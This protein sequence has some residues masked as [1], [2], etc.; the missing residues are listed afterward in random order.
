M[1]VDYGLIALAAIVVILT[2]GPEN[3]SRSGIRVQETD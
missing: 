2:E 3:L 1:E